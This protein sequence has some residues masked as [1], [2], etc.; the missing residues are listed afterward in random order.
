MLSA[1]RKHMNPATAVAFVAMV[2]AITGG[3]FAATGGSGGG[4]A[5]PGSASADARTDAGA[6]AAK[7]KSKVKV[8]PRGPRGAAGSA[9]PAGPAG[10]Q[11]PAGPAGT[12]GAKGENGAPGTNGTNGTDGVSGTG[13]TTESFTGKEH[14]CETGG[15]IVKSASPEAVVCN[16]KN[17]QSGFTEMLPA[18]KTETG[19]W[20]TLE[21]TKGEPI[22]PISLAIPVN[23]EGI[24]AHFVKQGEV[25]PA[26][27]EG[28]TLEPAAQ[29]GNLCV[30]MGWAGENVK[31]VVFLNAEGG[32]H[33][34][35]T[36][37]LLMALKPQEEGKE[38][39]GSGSY[40]VTAPAT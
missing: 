32:E 3:A 26:G 5:R 20:S 6:T 33:V 25:D 8:G 21:G 2:F 30:F 36:A 35:G 4:P 28:E 23:L 22:V 24:T 39:Q 31:N 37:G 16:G 27:C 13:A 14:G 11:G 29:P 15:V 38:L 17:G 40:A 1:V 9:G 18:G 10:P 7:S 34:R 19:V 12:A